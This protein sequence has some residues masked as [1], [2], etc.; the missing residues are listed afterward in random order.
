DNDPYA[1]FSFHDGKAIDPD[2][3]KWAKIKYRTITKTDNTGV[4]LIGQFYVNPAAEPFI[5]VKYNH[6]QKWETLVVDLTSVSEKASSG[7]IWDSAH[8][9]G[10]TQIRFDPMESNRDAE[11]QDGEH[12]VA[13]V[14]DGDCI[15]IAWIAF[16]ESEA[17]AKA[18][19]GTQDT[20]A[21]IILPEDLESYTPGNAIKS[22][23]LMEEEAKAEDPGQSGDDQPGETPA[24]SDASVVAIATVAC[25]ALAGVVVAAKKIRK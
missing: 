13:R 9:S 14:Q 10:K 7:S 16:F 18:Y 12:D 24:T 19:D 22:I 23:E 6:T 5:P 4:E 17:D 21:V 15:D 1:N 11:A 20:P 8:Y 3:V 2:T 25:I